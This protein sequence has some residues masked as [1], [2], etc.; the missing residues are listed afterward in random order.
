MATRL[1]AVA[2]VMEAALFI[3]RYGIRTMDVTNQ[4]NSTVATVMVVVQLYVVDVVAMDI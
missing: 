1:C 4:F 2:V 3:H